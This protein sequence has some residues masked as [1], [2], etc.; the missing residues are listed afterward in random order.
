M[1]QSPDAKLISEEQNG[2]PFFQGKT[3]FGII[4][5]FPK[6]WILY[7]VKIALQNDIL[8][9]VRAP[10]GALNISKEKCCIGRGLAAIRFNNSKYLYYV[11]HLVEKPLNVISSGSTF[12]AISAYDLKSIYIPFVLDKNQQKTITSFLDK[13]IAEIDKLIEKDKK[14]IELLK[15]KRID[16]INHAVTKGLDPNAKMKESGIEWIS[17]IPEDWEVK[18]LKFASNVFISNVDKKIH[19]DEDN[20]LL[21]NY[22]NVY[23]NEFITSNL[24]FMQSTASFKQIKK[25]SISK[26]DVIITKDSETIEEIAVPALVVDDLNNIICGYHLSLIRSYKKELLGQYLFRLFQSKKFSEQ[27]SIK[28]DGVTRFGISTYPIKNILI[29]LPSKKEQKAIAEYLNKQT[30]K[31]DKTIQKIEQKIALLEEYKKSIIH[32]VV[33]GK[34]DVREVI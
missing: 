15:E 21:C 30:L 13:K 14:L 20:I 26:D 29:L 22:I 3:E 11:L 2:V 32:H 18:K 9:T 16:L 34:I 6:S 31:I 4:Y 28:A 5:P 7:P 27:F 10:V 17:E 12:E 1:G 8:F 33:T 23:N 24:E 19:S 25:L